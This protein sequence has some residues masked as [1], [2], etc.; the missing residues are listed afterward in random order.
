MAIHPQLAF[1]P[2]ERWLKLSET[3]ID[4]RIGRRSGHRDWSEIT[5]ILELHGAI[6]LVVSS[7]N[8]FIV[9]RR[10]FEAEAERDRFLRSA[11]L[12]QSAARPRVAVRA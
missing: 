3:G 9:P 8:A 5:D 12:W 7:G 10:A 4:T 1:K 6:C 2:Q 11:R